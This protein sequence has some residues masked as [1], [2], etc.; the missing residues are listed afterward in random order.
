MQ[1]FESTLYSSWLSADI[2]PAKQ[3][4][5]FIAKEKFPGNNDTEIRNHDQ[6]SR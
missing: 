5:V 4:V 6:Y 1:T 2:L 3:P